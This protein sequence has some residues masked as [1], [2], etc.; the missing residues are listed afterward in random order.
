MLHSL[1]WLAA[2]LALRRPTLL[3]I[4]DLHWADVPSLRW[5]AHLQP[6]LDGLPLLVV[7]ATRPPSASGDPQLVLSI[8]GDPAG[9]LLRPSALGRESAAVLA[10]TIFRVEPGPAFV[11]ACQAASGGNPLFLEALLETLRAEGVEPVDAQAGR[12]AEVGPRPVTRAVMLRLSRVS[13]QAAGL[14]RAVAVLGGHAELRTAAALA[15]QEPAEA[16]EAAEALVHAD[17]LADR[18][19]LE[20]THP[21]VRAA[22]YD[23][24]PAAERLT[25][26]RRAAGV[27]AEA[28]VEPEQVAAHLVQAQPSADP[29]VVET[30]RHAGERALARGASEVAVGFLRRALDEPPQP[31]ERGEILQALGLAERLVDNDAAIV[32]LAE[33]LEA[34]HGSSRLA[35]ELSRALQRANRNPEAIEVLRRGRALVSDD[36]ESE[37]SMT[38]E[39]IGAAWWDPEDLD[40]AEAELAAAR[41]LELG[42]DHSAQLLRAI[43]A[44]GEA[45]AGDDQDYALRLAEEARD[46]R[47]LIASGSRALYSLGYVFTVAGRTDET[48][49]LFDEA[50]SGALRRGDYVL[51]STCHLFAALA[52]LFDGDLVAAAE[53]V[54]RVTELADLQAATPYHAGF[55]ACV[56]LERGDLDAAQSLLDASGLPEDVPPNGQFMYFHLVRGRLRLEQGRLDAAIR[57]L[58]A[59]GEHSRALGHRNPAFMPWQPYAA[60]ALHEAGRSA[61]AG[62]LVEAALGRARIWGA[63]HMTGTLL[64]VRGVLAGGA[65]GVRILEEAV[66]LLASSRAQLELARALVELGSALAG[67]ARRTDAR[68]LLRRG[69]ELAHRAGATR[70]EERARVEL[71]AAGGRPRRGS[72]TGVE[73]LTP[74][75]RRVAELAAGAMTNKAIAQEL[76]VTP[77]TVEVHL[78]SVYRKLEIASRS[79]L[80]AVLA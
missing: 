80:A 56:A 74:S 1:Y 9:S 58:Q 21:V 73:A 6:R 5:L 44:Y 64:R 40:L 13:P 62:E 37:R 66:E 77:K 23:E 43:L 11:D 2:N 12:V 38:A 10:R 65:E 26:H 49:A 35:L 78:S 36:P 76:F 69:L 51:A 39:L 28:R 53:D 15:G 19:P 20:F 34:S 4:D 59:L 50:S 72:L 22:V 3:A 18:L 68:E 75:E 70:L 42:D 47:Q 52:R 67:G 29:F 27:L 31:G 54:G 32:H 14:A 17:L 25:W 33:A 48:L 30:L 24:L 16:T 71:V 41:R 8:V 7:V 55:A 57:D 45:R 61:E 60:L 63:P 46:S 79:E